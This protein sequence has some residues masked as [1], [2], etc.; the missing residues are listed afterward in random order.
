VE[1]GAKYLGGKKYKFTLWGPFLKDVALK[2]ASETVPME[3]DEL[4]YWHVTLDNVPPKTHYFYRLNN[5]RELPDPA[6]FSQPQGIHG[7]TQVVD[8]S[9]FKWEDKNWSGIELQK[10]IIYEL[11]VGT[12][13]SE[14]NFTAI[15]KRLNELKKLGINT[16]ELMPVAQFPNERNWGYDGVFPFAV[17]NSYGGPEGFKKLVNEAHKNGIAIILDVVYNHLGPEGNYLSE[18]GPYFTNKYKTPWGDAINF[19][20]KYN[21]E[22]RNYFIENALYWFREYHIDALRLDAIH[23]IYDQSDHPFLQELA[24]KVEQFSKGEGR[25][26]YLTAESDLNDSRVV[27]SREK[28]GYGLDAQW[29]DDFHHCVHALLTGEK[30]GYYADFGKLEHLAKAI[31][32]GYVYSGEYSVYRKKPHGNS[33]KDI[34]ANRFIIFIQNHDQIG[35]RMHGERL[36]QLVSFEMLKFATGILFASP[37]I[38]LIFMGEEYAEDSPFLYFVSHYDENLIKA[39]KE[40]RMEQFAQAFHWKGEPPDPQSVDTFLK[41]KLKWNLR[42]KKKHA[43]MLEYYKHL[44][45]LRTE[46]PALAN[47]S[48][49]NFKVHCIQDKKILLLERWHSKSKILCAMSFNQQQ[50]SFP[51]KFKGRAEKLVD[52]SDIKWMGP[53]SSAPEKAEKSKEITM[54]PYNFILYK[55]E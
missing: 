50:A 23:G 8:H 35:N 41:S 21:E 49:E 24:E 29:N 54:R 30:N 32:E 27:R 52:S 2:I 20:G 17:Q 9:R 55:M 51:L 26:Y 39:S 40:S 3:K 47:L 34:P 42:N 18:F 33:S 6:S 25:K 12:F 38:P 31:R 7:P 43:V 14:G 37:N 22:V 13:T 11:H 46:I 1:I 16:I 28:G 53:G 4:G 10:M 5:S 45:K 36:S 44:I 48:K 15:I 19:D